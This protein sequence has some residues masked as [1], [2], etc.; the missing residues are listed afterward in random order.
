MLTYKATN[1]QSIYDICLMTY[2]SFDYLRKLI[3][4]NPSTTNGVDLGIDN[5]I[6]VG[7]VFLWDETLAQN[8]QVNQAL[9]NSSIILA[10]KA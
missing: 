6:E 8:Q 7:R 4:D 5:V 9:T 1:N 10:T 3:E 2:G